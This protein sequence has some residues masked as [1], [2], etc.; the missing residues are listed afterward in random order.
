MAAVARTTA[1]SP[2]WGEVLQYNLASQAMLAR[3]G[4]RHV[5]AVTRQ[6]GQVPRVEPP[7]L[8]YWPISGW[9]APAP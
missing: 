2:V 8:A 5:G 4:W 9:Q 7:G 1:G 3:A 6:L